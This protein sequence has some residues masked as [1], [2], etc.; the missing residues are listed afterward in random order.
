M[1]HEVRA[2]GFELN[3]A[4][5]CAEK[6]EGVVECITR[7][8]ELLKS[9][10]GTEPTQAHLRLALGYATKL[11]AFS[12][13]AEW[14]V[15]HPGLVIERGMSGMKELAIAYGALPQAVQGGSREAD[16][17]YTS[18]EAFLAGPASPGRTQLHELLRTQRHRPNKHLTRFSELLEQVTQGELTWSEFVDAATSEIA[19]VRRADADQVTSPT[20]QVDPSGSR[21]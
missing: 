12:M 2:T 11:Y 16:E 8:L 20:P 7:S 6:S 13:G 3:M 1:T 10:E 5:W 15:G 17:L 9:I 14:E 18:I 4:G 19:A 21:R